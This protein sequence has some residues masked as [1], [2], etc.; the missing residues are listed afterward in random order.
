MREA[1]DAGCQTIGGLEMLVGQASEQFRWWT[2]C[3]APST[4]MR[5]AAVKRLS[6][7][8]TDEDYVV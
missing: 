4:I 8:R 7:F 1:T 5:D 6:E 2:G 3:D